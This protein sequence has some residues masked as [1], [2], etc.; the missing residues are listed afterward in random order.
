[1]KNKNWRR[2]GVAGIVIN[3][4]L[5]FSWIRIYV[6]ASAFHF[7]NMGIVIFWAFILIALDLTIVIPLI[8]YIQNENKT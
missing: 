8:H 7:A 3:I 4:Y 1:M 2:L 5:L 6:E